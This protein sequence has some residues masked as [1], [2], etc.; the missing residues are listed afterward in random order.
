MQKKKLKCS[1]HSARNLEPH[2]TKFGIR[3]SC[4]VMGCTVVAWSGST[5]TPANYST[6][7]MRMKAHDAFDELWKSGMFTRTEA[8]HKLSLYLGI[9][10]QSTHIGH[11]DSDRCQKVIEF[12]RTIV[13]DRV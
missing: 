5:S 8:Y 11:F 12:S 13:E 6:R 3:Y 2:N 7:Q 1:T 10:Q 4:P 9:I